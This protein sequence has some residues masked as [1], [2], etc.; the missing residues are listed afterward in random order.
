MNKRMIW[1]LSAALL[2]AASMTATASEHGMHKHHEYRSSNKHNGGQGA[3][4]QLA[5]LEDAL[6]LEDA[7]R[8]AWNV[9]A[10]DIKD[11]ALAR[12]KEHE[13]MREAMKKFK[14]TQAVGAIERIEAMSQK[15][16]IHQTRLTQMKQ[17]A[18][19]LMTQLNPTQQSV[20]N[21]EWVNLMGQDGR[22]QHRRH[23]GHK[24]PRESRKS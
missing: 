24:D 16:K 21:A 9:F 1:M 6:K 17:A 7:Q 22:Q 18:Q 4:V 5:K 20:F 12:E 10:K 23:W 3:V 19:G 2:S 11:L 14:D 15:L 8:P 13:S